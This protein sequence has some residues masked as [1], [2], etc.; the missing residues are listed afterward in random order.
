M[1]SIGMSSFVKRNYKALIALFIVLAILAAIFYSSIPR[2]KAVLTEPAPFD[3][4]KEGFYFKG[5]EPATSLVETINTATAIKLEFTEEVDLKVLKVEISPKTDFVIRVYDNPKV[6][7]IIP[8]KTFWKLGID[9]TIKVS[10]IKS[11]SG[12]DLGSDIERN[13][14]IVEPDNVETKHF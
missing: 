7:Q 14:R 6:V 13:L 9:Y 1:L 5:V 4:T 8:Y 11:L 3:V 12:E 10:N 2:E